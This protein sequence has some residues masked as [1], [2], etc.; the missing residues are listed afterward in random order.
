[1]NDFFKP[2]SRAKVAVS[3]VGN[4]S[5]KTHKQNIREMFKH[6]NNSFPR[7][8]CETGWGSAF[9][10]LKSMLLVRDLLGQIA[11]ANEF[12]LL[13][14]VDWF[15]VQELAECLKPVYD[16]TTAMQLKKLTADEFF[17][18]WLKC[19]VQLQRKSV[20]NASSLALAILHAMEGRETTLLS[21]ATFLAAIFVDSSYL[22]LLK[23]SQKT[24]A[25]A[26]TAE[27]RR[28]LHMLQESVDTTDVE[29]LDPFPE[30]ENGSTTA[31][32]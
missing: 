27:L 18:E 28:S 3:K 11:L 1:M 26:H 7:V 22:I 24:V 32:G 17:D 14:K 8:G 6:N 15:G 9:L 5:N 2:N 30:S 29:C 25:Q 13:S 10:M 20:N 16:T 19:K 31:C 23:Y 12:L 4:V 21:K